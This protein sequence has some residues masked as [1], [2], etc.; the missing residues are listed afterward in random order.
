MN[1]GSSPLGPMLEV[2][3][4]LQQELLL[5]EKLA[6]CLN[7]GLLGWDVEVQAAACRDRV[8]QGLHLRRRG[9][10]GPCSPPAL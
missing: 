2:S 7:G 8:D 1:T 10:L 4:H 9:R 5:I 3:I 6:G